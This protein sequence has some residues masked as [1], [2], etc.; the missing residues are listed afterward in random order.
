MTSAT[1]DTEDAPSWQ[2]IRG[3]VLR[4]AAG[5][6]IAT[7]TYGVS[8]GALATASG[9]TVTQ[10]CALSVL[11]FTGGSQFALIGVLG[12]GGSVASGSASAVLLGVRNLLY[13]A[14]L[15]APLGLTAWRR[16]AGAHL[17]IDEST[18]VALA[19][20]DRGECAARLGFWATG[21]AVFVLWNLSTLVGA[22]A[23]TAI[24]DPRD[25]GLDA[26]VPAAFI[27]LVAPRLRSL[28][29]WLTAMAAAA[30]ALAVVPVVPAGVPVLLA[31]LVPVIAVLAFKERAQ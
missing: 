5:V 6:G 2:D 28:P 19:A 31:A 29:T 16:A 1:E 27:A 12:A 4:T 13:G 24:G 26:A 10:A 9:L 23:G 21:L 11:T 14:R 18:A 22:V 3:P 8:F 30:V 17:V 7:G 15:A 20:E 25:Y